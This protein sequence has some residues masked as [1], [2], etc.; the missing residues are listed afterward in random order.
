MAAIFKCSKQ[1]LFFTV[2]E[3]YKKQVRCDRR[4]QFFVRN[5]LIKLWLSNSHVL[6]IGQALFFTILK[7]N[8]LISTT[9]DIE[10]LTNF[11]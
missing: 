6:L 3:C 5:S 11:S 10:L 8:Y 7:V 9:S 1:R 2:P 4:L